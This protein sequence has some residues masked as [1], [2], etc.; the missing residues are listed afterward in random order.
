MINEKSKFYG[1][2][3]VE[4][5][6]QRQTSW[7]RAAIQALSGGSETRKPKAGITQLV[8]PFPSPSPES[9]K[10]LLAASPPW[11]SYHRFEGALD[12]V[13]NTCGRQRKLY[14]L[15]ALCT[16]VLSHGVAQRSLNELVEN[17]S[18]TC[19]MSMSYMHCV[20]TSPKI[21][22]TPAPRWLGRLSR[23][24]GSNRNDTLNDANHWV[25]RKRNPCFHR[26]HGQKWSILTINQSF[27]PHWLGIIKH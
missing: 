26:R 10:G 21:D 14:F 16:Q 12:L 22:H 4:I 3:S 8:S 15:T 9:W 25:C 24:R 20:D 19:N 13:T 7:V 17:M 23:V 2:H 5:R 1:F 11:G 27:I 18:C 6:D